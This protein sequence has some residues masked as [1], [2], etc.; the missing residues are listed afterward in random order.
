M[1]KRVT[2][3][4]TLPQKVTSADSE[5]NDKQTVTFSLASG[6]KAVFNLEVVPAD[7]VADKTYV[8]QET[9]GRD[10][11]ALTPESL[12]DITSTLK[13]QQFYPAIGIR[14]DA[15]IEIIDG[16]RRRASAIM[17]EVPLNVLVTDTVIS[18]SDARDL[19]KA[20]QTAREHNLREIGL[21]LMAMKDSG[22]SQKEIAS[23]EGMSQSKVTRALQ[24]ASV[25]ATLIS[26]FP[27]QHELA[28]GDYKTLLSL[29]ES[30]QINGT[31]EDEFLSQALPQIEAIQADH[32]LTPDEAKNKLLSALKKV[33]EKV[34]A[35]QEKDKVL[36]TPLWEFSD[37]DRYARKRVK[38]RSFSYEFNR[39]SKDLQDELDKA[40]EGVLTRHHK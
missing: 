23:L 35:P 36:V 4:R 40:I 22:L 20:I 11:S 14:H 26:V 5:G 3:G 2:I 25:P 15:R 16:S 29:S 7:Q 31:T 8:E 12:K 9:N 34:L 17:C 21:R 19:A 18:A 33:V 24:A 39:M 28:F 13:L 1:S 27:V 32:S 37:K 30:L 38:G 10:Q 6:K